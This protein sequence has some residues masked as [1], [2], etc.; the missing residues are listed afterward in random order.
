[1]KYGKLIISHPIQLIKSKPNRTFNLD[2]IK[3]LTRS[4]Y[5]MTDLE[6]KKFLKESSERNKG[7]SYGYT[8]QPTLHEVPT[9]NKVE[10]RNLEGVIKSITPLDRYI[11]FRKSIKN[12]VKESFKWFDNYEQIPSKLDDVI[13]GFCRGEGHPNYNYKVFYLLKTLD[14]VSSS[15]VTN[16]LQRQAKRLSHPLPSDQYCRLLSTMCI[17]LIKIIEYHISTGTLE[18]SNQEKCFD[19]EYDPYVGDY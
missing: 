15:T 12:T 8:N 14:D 3:S 4:A 11:P 18:L 6:F 10:R 5:V 7:N 9:L 13:L 1:M 2:L 19:F 16:F 17:K